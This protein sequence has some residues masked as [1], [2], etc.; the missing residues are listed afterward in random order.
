MNTKDDNEKSKPNFFTQLVCFNIFFG[1]LSVFIIP[2]F[3]FIYAI[4]LKENGVDV[5]LNHIIMKTNFL[6][7]ILMIVLPF[8]GSG[9]NLDVI[10]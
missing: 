8:S 9:S 7:A 10:D 5:D 6:S 3:M 2:I 1:M 4:I